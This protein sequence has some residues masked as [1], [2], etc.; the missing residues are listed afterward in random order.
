MKETKL[1]LIIDPVLLGII[2]NFTS[3]LKVSYYG[4]WGIVSR[5]GL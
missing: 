5:F 2:V 4:T 1:V 3:E